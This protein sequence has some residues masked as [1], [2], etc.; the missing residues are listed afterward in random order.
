MNQKQSYTTRLL[1]NLAQ[2]GLKVR[3]DVPGDGNCFYHA[4]SDQHKRLGMPEQSAQHLR[5]T[6]V[7]YLQS[8]VSSSRKVLV[9]PLLLMLIL[10]LLR[11][12]GFG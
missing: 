1:E 12:H 11:Q 5:K 2:L 10:N 8:L 3:R 9:I 6:L 7:E 4:V